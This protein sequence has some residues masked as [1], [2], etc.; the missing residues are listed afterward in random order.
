VHRHFALLYNP[1]RLK[2]L[3]VDSS[4]E[5]VQ[6]SESFNRDST[7]ATLRRS[8][9][10]CTGRVRPGTETA[11]TGDPPARTAVRSV[12]DAVEPDVQ[13]WIPPI[14]VGDFN[15]S[16][17]AVLGYLT[18]F[19]FVGEPDNDHAIHIFSESRRAT[20]RAQPS[21][22]RIDP[23]TERNDGG[24]MRGARHPVVRPLRPAHDVLDSGVM[25]AD[26]DARRC[27]GSQWPAG[28]R[29]SVRRADR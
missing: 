13:R 7:T 5:V 26:L 18:D 14:F 28:G 16:Q 10:C 4:A 27:G 21:R 8:M 2:N 1:Q 23:G 24:W 9:S 20:A 19:D 3:A 25:S 17:E 12:I 22:G 6:G 11:W 29:R 15:L